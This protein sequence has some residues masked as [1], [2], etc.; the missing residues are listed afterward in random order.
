LDDG[1]APFGILG[2]Q[3][4]WKITDYKKSKTDK[5]VLNLKATQLSNAAE[6]FDFN[7]DVQRARYLTD[8]IRLQEQIQRDEKMAE[9][10][11]EILE[12]MAAQV[13][14]GVITV[15]DYII[16]VNAGLRVS[17]NQALHRTE[18]LRV[19]LEFWNEMGGFQ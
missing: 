12:Q 1:L 9:L 15:S 14:E 7:L 5:E 13:D 16:Q 2:M 19:Q 10:Q 8:V 6:S 3:F 18:L 11:Q 17:T 4:S